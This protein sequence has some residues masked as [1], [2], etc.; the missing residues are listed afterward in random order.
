MK[1]LSEMF[2]IAWM[3]TGIFAMALIELFITHVGSSIIS[4]RATR[5]AIASNNSRISIRAKT[6]R[7]KTSRIRFNGSH[8]KLIFFIGRCCIGKSTG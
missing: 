7:C 3:R 8:V 5:F 2:Q 6:S 4:Q 1:A